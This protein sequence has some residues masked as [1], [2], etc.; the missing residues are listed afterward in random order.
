M[1]DGFNFVFIVIFVIVDDWE[2]FF[3]GFLGKWNIIVWGLFILIC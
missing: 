3:L 2:R 1:F